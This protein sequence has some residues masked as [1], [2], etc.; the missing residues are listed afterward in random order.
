MRAVLAVI[1]Y[2]LPMTVAAQEPPF[3]GTWTIDLRTPEERKRKVECGLATFELVQTG[4]LI[5]GDHSFSTVGCGRLNEGG[6]ETVKGVVVGKTAVLTVTSGRNGAVVMGKATLSGN[7]MHWK[8]LHEI[9]PGEPEGDSPLI[10][11]NGTLR[12]EK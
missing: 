12:R 6:P 8:I 4:D 7:R 10:L 2:L 3:T 11:G 1:A 9:K 5:I